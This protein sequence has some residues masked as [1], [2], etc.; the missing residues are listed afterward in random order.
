MRRCSLRY[1]WLRLSLLTGLLLAMTACDDTAID[2]FD[3][4]DRFFTLYGYL[5]VAK[6]FEPDAEH[7]LRV[8]PITR[9]P[10]RIESPSDDQATID[11]VVTSIDL[12]TGMEQRWEHALE[13]LSDG[14]YAHIFRAAFFIQPRRTYRLEVRRSDGVTASAE[15]T[16]PSSQSI[17]ATLG[18]P[19][20]D[21]ETGRITQEMHLANMPSPWDIDVIYRVGNDFI[22]TPY[23]LRYGRV[24]TPTEDDGWRFTIDITEDRNRLSTLLGLAPATIQ[25]PNMALQIR[26]LDGQWTPP[27]GLFDPEVLAQPGVLSNV[28]NGYG[29]WGS[30]GLYQ[31]NWR[32]SDELRGLLG[33]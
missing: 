16:I 25:F 26:L 2:P 33:F 3:N 17:E 6:N 21:P 7:T 32:V 30:I 9:F 18:P 14:T 5:D 29:F 15:T 31:H 22:A 8:I 23:P 28:E 12:Q 11:A 27:E 13:Q 20:V 4:D 1:P 24:G 19:L 10:E